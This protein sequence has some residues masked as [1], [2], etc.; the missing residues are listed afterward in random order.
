VKT[1]ARIFFPVIF[2]FAALFLAE[3]AIGQYRFQWNVDLGLQEQYTDNVDLSPTDKEE[4]Y[5]TTIAPGGGLTLASKTGSLNLDYHLTANFY[6]HDDERN[7]LGHNAD[8]NIN[9]TFWR[10][11]TFKLRNRF[12]RTDE[13]REVI[14]TGD[15]TGGTEYY[16]GTSTER[17]VYNRNTASLSLAMRYGRDDTVTLGYDY[18]LYRN[19]SVTVEDSYGHAYNLLLDHWFGS[20]YGI[21]VGLGYQMI[22]FEIN[23]DLDG[24]DANITFTRKFNNRTSAF[25]RGSFFDRDFDEGRNDYKIYRG[26]IGIDHALSRILSGR[27]DV[28]YFF[29]DTETGAQDDDDNGFDGGFSLTAT[30]I[31]LQGTLFLRSGFEES[32]NDSENLGFANTASAGGNLRYQATRRI[33]L[34]IDGTY[35][36]GN[37]TDADSRRITWDVGAG[38]T[39]TLLKWLFGSLDYLYRQRI[40]SDDLLDYEENRLTLRLAARY[41]SR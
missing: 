16:I 21:A 1:L 32:F 13:H 20:G 28:G 25:I 10:R 31:R 24:Q 33:S 23:P 4:E 15:P 12:I 29:R 30:W 3:G 39:I 14:E 11:F 34:G 18:S 17:S 6:N 8:L 2:F 38:L 40:A 26:G 35:W 22:R 27:L 41:S 36:D 19:E 37:F 5:I 9:Q 7:Y